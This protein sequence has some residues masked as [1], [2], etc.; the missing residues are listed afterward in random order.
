MSARLQFDLFGSAVVL[1]ERLV[2]RTSQRVARLCKRFNPLQLD[3]FASSFK[4]GRQG[5]ESLKR[6]VSLLLVCSRVRVTFAFRR[7]ARFFFEDE[8]RHLHVVTLSALRETL[9]YGGA[10]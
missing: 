3:L 10:L 7:G 6:G 1:A 4:L 5:V 9:V 2:R 8:A